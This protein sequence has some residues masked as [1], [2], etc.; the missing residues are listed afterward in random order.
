M[1][2][3]YQIG[4]EFKLNNGKIYKP[5]YDWSGVAIQ[6]NTDGIVIGKNP[7]STAFFE[8]FPLDT[9]IRGEGDTVEEAETNAWNKYQKQ[10]HCKEHEY[11]RV[12]NRKD[13]YARCI[14]CNIHHS[15]IFNSTHTCSVCDVDDSPFSIDNAIFKKPIEDTINEEISEKGFFFINIQD[16]KYYCLTHFLEK[17]GAIDLHL[18]ARAAEEQI[19][20]YRIFQ[21][22]T[23]K[24]QYELVLSEFD[25]RDFKNAEEFKRFVY[26]EFQA[27][28]TLLQNSAVTIAQENDFKIKLPKMFKIRTCAKDIDLLTLMLTS[29]F[30]NRKEIEKD[31][32]NKKY[33]ITDQRFIDLVIDIAEK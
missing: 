15:R 7:Y 11:E 13:G 5:Q 33:F 8:A 16:E 10:L 9:F 6:A 4:N 20:S 1:L 2:T 24:I 19:N 23:D 3:T 30:I 14:H 18:L 27:Y 31:P 17:V 21:P 29:Y 28:H 22:L 26:K 32:T 12:P 25:Y